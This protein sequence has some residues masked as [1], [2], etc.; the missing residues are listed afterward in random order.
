MNEDEK[1]EENWVMFLFDIKKPFL[2]YL[3]NLTPIILFFSIGFY[4]WHRNQ[5]ELLTFN[6]RNFADT[7][8]TFAVF[9]IA[10]LALGLNCISFIEEIFKNINLNDYEDKIKHLAFLETIKILRESNL[11]KMI[12]ISCSVFFVSIFAIVFASASAFSG[13]VHN[14]NI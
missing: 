13:F 1:K 2:E 9:I 14:L 8:I 3:R 6:L 4:L 10:F 12:I 5:F 7:A 11:G